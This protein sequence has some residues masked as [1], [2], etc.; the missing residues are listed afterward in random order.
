MKALLEYGNVHVQHIQLADYFLG[1]RLEQWYF[2][3]DW[4]TGPF[5]W[6]HLSDALRF[7]TLAKYGGYYFDTDFV[8]LDSVQVQ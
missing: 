1:S 5:A 2:C 3:G 7:L 6:S 4:R 8:I